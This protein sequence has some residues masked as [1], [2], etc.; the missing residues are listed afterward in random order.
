MDTIE[1][2]DFKKFLESNKEYM[3][4]DI[5]SFGEIRRMRMI[6]NSVNMPI[7]EIQD[8]IDEL[9]DNIP[10]FIVCAVGIR[11]RRIA[12]VLKNAGKDAI[13]L[14]GGINAYYNSL[15]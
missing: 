5:R 15:I 3:I 8:N 6:E 13:V 11:A 10:L 12:S 1:V 9:P 7:E 2:K 4:I 14:E